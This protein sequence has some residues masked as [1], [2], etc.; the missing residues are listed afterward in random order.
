MTEIDSAVASFIA[1]LNSKKEPDIS[2]DKGYLPLSASYQETMHS[3]ME[4]VEKNPE[5]FIMTECIPAC[6]ACWA[7]NVYTFMVSDH[8]NEGTCWIEVALENLSDENKEI[9]ESFS[10]DDVTKFSYHKGTMAF[11]VKK[12][13]LEGERRLLELAEQFKMQ[14]VPHK[15]A[16]LTKE[17]FLIQSG[18]YKDVDNPEYVEMKPFWQVNNVPHEEMM[19]YLKRYTAWQNSPRS[20]KTF[21]EFDESKMTRPLQEYCAEAGAILDG[22]GIYLSEYHYEKHQRYLASKMLD[23]ISKITQAPSLENTSVK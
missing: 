12:V 23:D 4:E 7:N 14:D 15:E 1:N 17:E 9:L 3:P 5:R 21:K 11:G 18:C 2:E 16:W 10:G 22:E 20:I 19:D 6:Q 13:G 8:L